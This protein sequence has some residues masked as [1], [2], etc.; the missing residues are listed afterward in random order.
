MN[1]TQLIE[2]ELEFA[3]ALRHI[4]PRAGIEFYGP[5]DAN[6]EAAPRRIRVGLVGDSAG[7]DG[8]R[9]WLERC[10]EP[11][12][13]KGSHQRNLFTAW[14]GFA[15]D[16]GFMATLVFDDRSERVLSQ[17]AMRAVRQLSLASRVPA[18]VDLF[19]AEL[20][21]LADDSRVD[22][23][24]CVRPDDLLEVG[25]VEADEDSGGAAGV[26]ED[27][28]T[29]D[30]HDLLKARA[31][32]LGRPIQV[33]RPRTFGAS[34]AR[35]GRGPR[36]AAPPVQDEATRAWNIHGALYYKAGGAPWRLRSSRG[37]HT[38]CYVGVSFFEALDGRSL[39]TGVAQVFNER[40]DGVITRGGQAQRS[41]RDRQVHLG[42]NDAAKLLGDALDLY[43]QH[44]RTL[45]ARVVLHKT[46]HFDDAERDGFLRAADDRGVHTTELLWIMRSEDLRLFRLG[47]HPPLRGTLLSLAPGRHVLY[48]R[49]SVPYYATYPGMYIP[50]PIG[51]RPEIAESSG[52]Q[53]AEEVMA[54]T[55]LNWN[56]TQFDGRE[57]VT[58]RIADRVGAIMRYLDPDAPVVARYAYYM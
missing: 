22:V 54:L 3:G 48:T 8:L 50:S 52:I 16:R 4:D 53:L 2:P 13:D 55:K 37:D 9:R 14:P 15:D 7:V 44:H 56:N 18:L 41:K 17:R 1:I 47:E 49:G 30:F 11:I 39:H 43:R 19:M 31:M 12:A 25:L 45:P 51:I 28:S 20:A 33:V 34:V 23:A 40:G 29:R 46:S 6:T 57:P 24:L 58:I 27:L 5:A 36:R 38:S 42:E 10:R 26:G 21:S 32:S 35:R